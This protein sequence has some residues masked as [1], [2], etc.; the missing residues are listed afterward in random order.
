MKIRNPY[1][2]T[3]AFRGADRQANCQ[4]QATWF[5][6][7]LSAAISRACPVLTLVRQAVWSS[8]GPCDESGWFVQAPLLGQPPLMS[9]TSLRTSVSSESSTTIRRDLLF[10]VSASRK[11]SRLTGRDRGC[12][13][14]SVFGELGF[15]D[16]LTLFIPFLV[17]S[18]P[19]HSSINLKSRRN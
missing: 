16:A 3:G 13:F 4:L 14:R 7:G 9:N 17:P 6:R 8:H 11:S 1:L 18:G 5:K 15:H 10:S 12:R 19:M 2:N